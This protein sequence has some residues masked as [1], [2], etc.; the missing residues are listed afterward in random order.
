[1]AGI[2]ASI[3]FC[4]IFF[5]S[6]IIF[7]IGGAGSFLFNAFV[8]L[9]TLAWIGFIFGQILRKICRIN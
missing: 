6:E 7:F 5:L 3:F 8:T 2:A 1:M 9:P 4:I